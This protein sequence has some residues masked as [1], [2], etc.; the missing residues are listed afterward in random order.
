MGY[1]KLREGKELVGQKHDG[2]W[3]PTFLERKKQMAKTQKRVRNTKTKR[4]PKEPL[5]HL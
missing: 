1:V 5:N 2:N 3:F 4:V